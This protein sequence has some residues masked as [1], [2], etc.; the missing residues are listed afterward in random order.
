MVGG[1]SATLRWNGA[2]PIPERL[3]KERMDL[4]GN[5]C[6]ACFESSR[7]V[8]HFDYSERRFADEKGSCLALGSL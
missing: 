5:T 1:I 6:P 7:W 4:I 2:R 3:S 8:G